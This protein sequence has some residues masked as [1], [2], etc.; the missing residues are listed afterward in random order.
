MSMF[1]QKSRAT[2]L[3]RASLTGSL[4]NVLNLLMAFAYRAAFIRILSVQYLGIGSMFG[5]LMMLLSL[6]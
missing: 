2:N 1:N 3:L 6:A 4:C 5:N